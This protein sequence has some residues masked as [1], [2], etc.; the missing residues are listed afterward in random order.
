M[1]LFSRRR[2]EPPLQ[3]YG[4]LPIAKDYL[5][6]GAGDGGGRR[7]REWLDASYSG[8]A[9]GTA[10]P[11]LRGALRFATG[12]AGAPLQGIVRPSCDDGGLRRVPFALFVERRE[13]ALRDELERDFAAAARW[14]ERL[15]AIAAEAERFADGAALLQAWRGVTVAPAAADAADATDGVPDWWR[16]VLERD[17][18]RRSPSSSLFFSLPDRPEAEPAFV[19]L[20]PGF[21]T[22]ALAARLA[23]PP[24][25]R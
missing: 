8:A 23:A 21:P 3:A 9:A 22:P 24:E 7:L 20:A 17:E 13:K 18:W 6:V 15:E 16:R 2:E 14:W 10:P 12:G 25:A 5:R 1:G 11:E 4:K 19:L